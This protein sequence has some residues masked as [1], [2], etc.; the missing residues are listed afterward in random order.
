M[1]VL[2][3]D[4]GTRM[5]L[6]VMESNGKTRCWSEEITQVDP[7]VRLGLLYDLV[8]PRL[9]G[10]DLIVIEGYAFMRQ[11]R[12]SFTLGEYG[13]VLRLAFL[14]ARVPFVVV[15]PMSL[16]KFVMGSG[17]APGKGSGKNVGALA[18]A[19]FKRWGVECANDNEVDAFG[20]MQIGVGILGKR[21][22]LIQAQME[23][24]TKYADEVQKAHCE[25]D[26]SIS[27]PQGA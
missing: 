16:K 20:L 14:A 7:V 24:V 21:D 11:G 1:R 26:C 2:G 10:L 25:Y 8:K 17:A 3:L 13:G 6:A 19:A 12:G 22:G 23:V 4:P 18:V 5:G 9:K 15:A 27:D